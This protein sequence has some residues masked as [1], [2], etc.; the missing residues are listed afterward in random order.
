MAQML[1]TVIVEVATTTPDALV[2]RIEF[3]ATDGRLSAPDIV[4]EAVERNPLRNP[5]VVDV[6]TPQDCE[7][8]GKAYEVK[9]AS[10]LNQERLIEEEAIVLSWLF[11]P[12]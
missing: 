10:L 2:E 9:P 6:D 5:R 11:D 4:E 1:L 3:I 8:N 12:I 7:V